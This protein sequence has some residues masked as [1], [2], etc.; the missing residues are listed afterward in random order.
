LAEV[1]RAAWTDERLD[2]LAEAIRSGFGRLDQDNRD[3]RSDMNAGLTGLRG[4]IQTLRTEM[5]HEFSSLRTV[6]FTFGGGIILALMGV[7]AAILARG[8]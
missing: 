5:Q 3:L 4:E 8:V 2:D 6:M 7:I 1:E